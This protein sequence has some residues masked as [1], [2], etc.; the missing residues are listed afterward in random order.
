[1]PRY[2]ITVTD[3][4]SQAVAE[5]QQQHNLASW[6]QAAAALLSH[7]L[8]AQQP[9]PANVRTWGGSRELPRPR[10]RAYKRRSRL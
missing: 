6:S 5:Y 8:E 3:E 1:M 2:T 10:K 9:P 4:M 7:G